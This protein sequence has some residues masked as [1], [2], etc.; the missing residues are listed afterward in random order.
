MAD[1]ARRNKHRTTAREFRVVD[2]TAAHDFV[3]EVPGE[4]R[5]FVLL[6]MTGQTNIAATAHRDVERWSSATRISQCTCKSHVFDETFGVKRA[7]NAEFFV[8]TPHT[9]AMQFNLFGE[10]RVGH[11]VKGGSA[12]ELLV[13]ATRSRI[14]RNRKRDPRFL[15]LLS[16]YCTFRSPLDGTSP[17][18]RRMMR[19]LPLAVLTRHAQTWACS[20]D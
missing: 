19:P 9:V 3:L 6:D 8:A 5:L 15:V 16:R 18:G 12:R 4:A 17:M 14:D 11:W 2:A 20:I 7:L 13:R 1:Q 10:G